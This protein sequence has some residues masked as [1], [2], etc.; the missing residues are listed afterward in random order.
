MKVL[1]C[2]STS[3]RWGGVVHDRIAALAEEVRG[4]GD[5]LVVL[6]AGAGGADRFAEEAARDL[7]LD[8]AVFRSG[9]DAAGR[10]PRH[11]HVPRMIA[12]APD[13]VLAFRDAGGSPGTDR[14]VEEARGRGIPVEEVRPPAGEGDG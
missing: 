14:V 4:R 2:G 1:V 3:W 6:T 12:E 8:R 11:D 13:M 7:G 5:A 9:W 10:N